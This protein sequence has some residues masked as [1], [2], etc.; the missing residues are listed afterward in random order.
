MRKCNKLEE[1]NMKEQLKELLKTTNSRYFPSK[2]IEKW[3]EEYHKKLNNVEHDEPWLTLM[4]IYALFGDGE[5]DSLQK[6]IPA[7]NAILKSSEMDYPVFS[8]IYAVKVERKLVKIDSLKSYMKGKLE[9]TNIKH[10]YPDRIEALKKKIKI[11][12]KIEGSTNLD[13][14]ICGKDTDGNNIALYIEA[15]FLS[16]ISHDTTYLI[17]RDQIIR[18]IDALIDDEFEDFK[19]DTDH[20]YF[21]LLT[22]ELFKESIIGNKY[23][24][25]L[26]PASSRLYCYKYQEYK[27]A[28]NLKKY[29]PYRTDFTD[30][31]WINMANRVGW[32]T[33]DDIINQA[34]KLDSND[35]D[36]KEIVNKFF[37]E[38]NL[39]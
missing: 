13:L 12:G 11:N 15:K 30:A 8:A 31:D 29:L 39:T 1:V 22:P 20:K 10:L 9:E 3:M 7:L 33:F 35:S 24:E 2:E 17:G 5:A 21:L 26:Y 6:G 32:I 28:A 19:C 27:N 23:I 14:Y 37:K 4:A 16:D 38:R 25:S 36:F 18:N 34:N